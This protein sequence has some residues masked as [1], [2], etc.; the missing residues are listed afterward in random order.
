MLSP[1]CRASMESDIMTRTTAVNV[2]LSGRFTA[3]AGQHVLPGVPAL[4]RM[5]LDQMRIDRASGLHNAAFVS[6]YPGSPLGGLDLELSRRNALLEELQIV[7]K[8]GLNEELAATAVFGSQVATVTPGAQYEGVLGAWYGKAPGLDRAADAIRHGNYAG[9]NPTS[10]TLVFV[11][12]DPACKS[13]TLPSASEGLCADLGLP[14]IHPADSQDILDLGHHAVELSRYSG[15]W[16][17]MKIVSAVADGSSTVDL[18]LD[19]VSVVA[20]E[21]VG[22]WH[23]VVPTLHQPHTRALEESLF[24]TRLPRARAYGRVNSLNRV[25]N[26]P[27]DTWLGLVAAGHTYVDVVEA[28]RLLGVSLDHASALGIRLIKIGMSWPLDH[29]HVRELT[30]GLDE[31]LV[32]EEGRPFIEPQ[33]REALYG[34]TGAPIVTG[35]RA[36]SND[37]LV[38]GWGALD[39]DKIVQPLRSRLALRVEPGRLRPPAPAARTQLTIVP[40]AR[41]PWFCSGCPHSNS[42]QVPDG[43]LVGT[44]IGCHALASRMDDNRTG[45]VLSNTQMGGEG[46]QW[47][48]AAPFLNRDHIF[49]NLGDGTLVHSGWL[50]IRFAIASGSHVTFKI[51]FNGSVAMTGGQEA[52]G[53][54]SIPEVIRGLRA[55]GVGKIIVTTDDPKAYRRVRL[56]RDVSVRDRRDTVAAQEELA[57]SPGVTVL[58][59][60]QACATDLRRARARGLVPK[61]SQRVVINERVCEGCGD[62]GRK[63]TCLSLHNVDTEYG[64]KTQVH[65][66][67]CNYDMACLEGDCPSFTLVEAGRPRRLRKSKTASPRRGRAPRSDE[68]LTLTEPQ[69]PAVQGGYVIRIPGIGGTGVV[70]VGQI[71]GMAA[72]LDGY[73][74]HG[75]D[76]TGMSQKAGPVVSDLHVSLPADGPRPGHASDR[77]VDLYLV[78][79]LLVANAP[80]YVRGI[81]SERTVLIGSS[82]WTPTGDAIG[83]PDRVT[84]DIAA[85]TAAITDQ[86]ARALWLDA[87]AESLARL[88]TALGANFL[89]VGVAY[90]AGA[91]PMSADSIEEAI[92]QNGVAVDANIEAF[93]TGREIAL[94]STP[95]VATSASASES[96]SPVLQTAVGSLSISDEQLRQRV[97]GRV[98]DLVDYQNEAYAHRYLEVLDAVA[99]VGP[100]ELTGAVATN[101]HKLMAYKD[102]YEVARLHTAP[103]AALAAADVVGGTPRITYVLHPPFLRALGMRRKLRIGHWF[104]AVLRMLCLGKRLRGTVFDPFGYAHV[105]RLERQLIA[106]YVDVVHALVMNFGRIGPEAALDIAS[107]PDIVSGYESIK[108]ASVARYRERLTEVLRATNLSVHS[109]AK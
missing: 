60:D 24:Q 83:H 57:G 48:G 44:G 98:A 11:G 106:E 88:G 51:L 103:G 85:A 71:L 74:V 68:S 69:R 37:C 29:E 99:S 58:I 96:L 38:P 100:D 105:R 30:S 36:P 63:S 20:P 45:T 66:T 86:T 95:E 40:K 41:P 15:V 55:E 62:C 94:E 78:F 35:K 9:T 43:A 102:E 108:V 73:S 6:G 72:S 104:G 109:A 53:Q 93:R 32:I 79:D 13:S 70:T 49:Q 76:Q 75:L 59:H 54:R 82:T 52:L 65:Q 31:V 3:E 50:A 22:P 1:L 90:Q 26:R 56:G 17:A 89:L 92:R 64:T 18:A 47:V 21:P 14:V 19:R 27:V 34:V 107:L 84:V 12:D 80:E 16:T 2:G 42:T 28:L 91:L 39:A 8:P 101:L 5:L 87:G 7:H 25:V 46:A 10:G 97:Q 33:I 77:T 23:R 81:T 4:V 61:P 67:S